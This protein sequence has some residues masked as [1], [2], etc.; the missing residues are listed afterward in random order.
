MFVLFVLFVLFVSLAFLFAVLL[1]PFFVAF[2]ARL[3][4]RFWMHLGSACAKPEH[5]PSS[6]NDAT[7]VVHTPH[8][9]SPVPASGHRG[10]EAFWRGLVGFFRQPLDF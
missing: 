10:C 2:H 1:A 7:G 6:K 4:W 9:A 3:M 8:A 5:G